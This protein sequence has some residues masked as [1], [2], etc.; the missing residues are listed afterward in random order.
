MSAV[1][2]KELEEAIKRVNETIS[3]DRERLWNKSNDLLMRLIYIKTPMQNE[4]K[5]TQEEINEFANMYFSL[6]KKLEMLVEDIQKYMENN[7]EM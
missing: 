4:A 3:K 7:L 6:A 2:P 1:S 5:F